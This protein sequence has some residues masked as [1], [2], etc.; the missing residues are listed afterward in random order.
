[1][2]DEL[3]RMEITNWTRLR[4]DLILEYQLDPEDMALIDTLEGETDLLRILGAAAREAEQREAM[5]DACYEIAK[6][7]KARAERLRGG[8][9]S[10]RSKIA[11]IMIEVNIKKVPAPDLTIT[12]RQPAPAP[13]VIDETALP[14]EYTKT[15][16]EMR[17][18]R[19]KIKAEYDRCEAEG[20]IF[21]VP[22]VVVS[23]AAPILTIRRG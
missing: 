10:L 15:K 13:K 21:S 7:K 8:A 23:N 5:A 4:D 6:T 20:R 16:V 1:M 22:G 19:D 12:V 17:A 3:V 2:R 11:A 18:D 9:N 14:T